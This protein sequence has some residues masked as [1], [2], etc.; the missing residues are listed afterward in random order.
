MKV[1]LLDSTLRE[2]EQSPYVSFTVDQKIKIVKALDSFGVE[3]I[4]IGHPVVSY[5]INQSISEI[6]AIDTKA[7]KLIHSRVLR[8]D[9]DNALSFGVPWIGMFFGTSDLSLKYKFGIDRPTAMARI[10]DAIF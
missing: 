10:I 4:E 5:D 2:G 6:S 8:S 9:I 7:E 3:F 1:A